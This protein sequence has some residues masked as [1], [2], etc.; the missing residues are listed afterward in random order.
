[1][2]KTVNLGD[3]SSEIK[4]FTEATLEEQQ[5]AVARGIIKSH[6]MLL[7][8][9]PV[10]TGQYAASWDFLITEKNAILGNFAPHAAIIER[11]ARPFRP[12]LQ[13]LLSW[14]KRVLK[15]PSQPPDYSD[16]VWAL[17]IHTRNKIEQ[18]GMEPKNVLEQAMPQIIENVKSELERGV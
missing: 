6:Q 16:S 1:L 7:E 18:S 4:G 11:G 5:A 9:S 2:A 8:N 17:A 3:F 14:A 10:D 13:P 15:D 12:P